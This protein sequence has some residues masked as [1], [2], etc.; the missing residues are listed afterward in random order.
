RYV[1]GTRSRDRIFRCC[2]DVGSLAEKLVFVP[3]QLAGGCR[4][5]LERVRRFCNRKWNRLRRFA[6][7][8]SSSHSLQTVALG[9][10]STAFLGG[11]LHARSGV[12][13]G[14]LAGCAG[15]STDCALQFHY[16]VG[17]SP[18]H[19]VLGSRSGHDGCADAVG[20]YYMDLP[21]PHPPWSDSPV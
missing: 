17:T 2:S 7:A 18:G 20:V 14:P 8:K 5:L 19:F 12:P 3:D 4:I 13:L 9:L 10:R 15:P 21:T 16:V 11:D 6:M 1:D